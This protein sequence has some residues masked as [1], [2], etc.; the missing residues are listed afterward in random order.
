MSAT[1]VTLQHTDVNSGTAVN[2]NV[3]SVSYG[4]KN[5][6]SVS[7]IQGKFDIA[8]ADFVGF[9]NPVMTITGTIDVD[10]GTSNMV[11]QSLLMDFAQADLSSGDLTLTVTAAGEGGTGTYL[12]GRPST[13]YSVGGTYT[14]SLKVQVL[15][16]S[17][18]FG[19]PESRE[20]RIWNYNLE[21]V[22]TI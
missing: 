5:M 11:T 21:L 2:M 15:G 7:P 10:D 6:A 18:N 1:D 3:H 19:V 14:N 22:E 12:K 13:G 4:W 17:I 16:F 8:T 9:E 20:G